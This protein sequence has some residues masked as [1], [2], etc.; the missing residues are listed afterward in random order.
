VKCNG[1]ATSP[2]PDATGNRACGAPATDYDE[3]HALVSLPI[4]QKGI[5]PYAD[6][7]GGIDTTAPVRNED[8]CVALTVPKGTMPGAGWP[9]VVFGHGTGGSFR[10]GIRPEVA[11]ALAKA[12]TP[13]A[14]LGFDEV[15]HGPR[16]GGSTA[17]PNVLFFNF[18]NP[19]AARGNPMQGAADVISIGRF[20]RSLSIPGGV[21]GGSAVTTNANAIL[22]FGHS[23]GSM[24]GSVGLPYTNDYVAAVLS[25]NGASIAHAL[26]SKTSPDNIA[27]AV[28]LVLGGDFELDG[29][30]KLFGGE[31]H[32][33][34]TLID[35]WIGPADPLNFA[36][37]TARRLGAGILPKSV[38]QTYG[39]NDS[40]SPP[41]TLQMYALAAGL[42]L[43]THDSS[44][45]TP[46]AFGGLTEQPV[47]LSGNF[48]SGGRT[49]TLAVREY[50]NATGKDGH[51]VVFDVASANADAVRFLSMAASGSVPQVGQ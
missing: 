23:Q 27:A 51:F 44:V 3:Y 39:L 50:Q 18:K 6:M 28:P 48:A 11:G 17:S 31:D 26:L 29:S 8:V 40:Y 14:V 7:G 38:L 34:L 49:V 21:T 10:D 47:P 33:V 19:D 32:P 25:G 30:G 15:E 43:A 2:C 36:R 35:Q 5:A 4:F 42:P 20:A 13:M 24:H 45:T 22:Y 41:I 16:R 9:L 1:S 46:D 37:G 12:P